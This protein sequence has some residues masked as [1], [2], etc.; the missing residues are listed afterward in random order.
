M[1]EHKTPY[2]VPWFYWVM[3]FN[4]EAHYLDFYARRGHKPRMALRL[5]ALAASLVD[6]TRSFSVD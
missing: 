1:G 3:R 4:F 2:I 5:A 6:I